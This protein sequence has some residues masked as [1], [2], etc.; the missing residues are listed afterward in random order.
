MSAINIDALLKE[1]SAD[2]PCGDDLEYDA[3]FQEMER[4]AQGKP[5]SQFAAAE[6]PD[7]GGVRAKAI[8]VLGRSKDLRAAVYLSQALLITNGWSGFSEGLALIQKLLE[9][10]WAAIHPRIDPEDNDPTLRINAV[11]TLAQTPTPMQ[12]ET[13]ITR[14]REVPLVSSRV[15]G[16]FSLRDMEIASG[17]LKVTPKADEVLADPAKINAAFRDSPPEEVQATAAALA[18]AI[19]GAKAI[20]AA[21]AKPL[22]AGQIPNLTA[23]V[24]ELTNARRAVAEHLPQQPSTLAPEAAGADGAAPTA[25]ARPVSGEFTSR[26]DVARMLDKMCEYFQRHEPSSPVPLLLQRAKRL[27]SKDFMDILKDL[28][29]DAVAKVEAISGKPEAPAKK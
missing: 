21:F 14:L 28:A 23:L 29:P 4:A 17:K 25:A 24:T 8:E 12:S 5:E 2:N 15:I 26:D 3:L 16:R 13:F 6:P 27:V 20:D 10:Y 7:W 9:R 22:G 1:I 18:S 19:D 11:A